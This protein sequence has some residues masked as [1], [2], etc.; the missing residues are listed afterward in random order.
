MTV[1]AARKATPPKQVAPPTTNDAAPGLAL[2]PSGSKR[3]TPS[4]PPPVTKDPILNIDVTAPSS[5]PPV[6]T[7]V[8]VGRRLSKDDMEVYSGLLEVKSTM[9]KAISLV[10]SVCVCVFVEGYD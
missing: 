6:V 5:P 10:S 1:C 9:S 3:V 2:P 4:P 8:R 7:K